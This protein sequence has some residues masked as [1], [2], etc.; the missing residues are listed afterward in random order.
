MMFFQ[1]PSILAFQQRLQ[2]NIQRNNLKTIF[3]ITS[4]PKDTQLRDSIDP[5]PTEPLNKIFDDFLMHLQRGKYLFEYQFYKG[6]YLIPVDGSQYFS[7]GKIHCP[8]CLK[9]DKGKG[10]VRY[11]HQILQQFRLSGIKNSIGI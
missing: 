9:K 3:N 4:I 7:S 8:K 1:D 10:K 6:M 5:L 2:D 11:H